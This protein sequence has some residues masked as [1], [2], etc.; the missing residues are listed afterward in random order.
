MFNNNKDK[1]NEKIVDIISRI[2]EN[3]SE[4]HKILKS[5][6][7]KLAVFEKDYEII[8][9]EKNNILPKSDIFIKSHNSVKE[10]WK[11]VDNLLKLLSDKNTTILDK[12]NIY[13][14]FID[15]IHWMI[16]LYSIMISEFQKQD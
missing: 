10:W 4:A 5:A 7:D 15:T 6:W 3:N 11:V 13:P 16:L 1:L 12:N 2:E 9:K 8:K 14:I